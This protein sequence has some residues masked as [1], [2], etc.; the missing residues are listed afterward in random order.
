MKKLFITLVAMVGVATAANAQFNL[1]SLKNLAKQVAGDKID[2]VVPESVQQLLGIAVKE[3]DIPGT[4]TYVKAAVEFE[5]ANALTAAGGTVAAET[6]EAKIEPYL[7]KIGIKEGLFS[8]TFGED[9]TFSTKLGSKEVK[10][11]WA[12]NKEAETVS[13]SLKDGGKSFTTR[14]VVNVD[15]IN[16]LFKA[17]SLLELLKS[18]S[19]NS[20]NTTI[21]AIGA[22]V[23]SYD[24]MNI[25]FECK[26]K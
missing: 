13:L 3:V 19:N 22:V 21:A 8:F 23:K 25:G 14:M 6:V 11:R 4:W 5:S 1:G 10:G 12:Y 26:K 2:E 20:S 18:I 24:G 17:D 7:A 15:N 16:I 9:G